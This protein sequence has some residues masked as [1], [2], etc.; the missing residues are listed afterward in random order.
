MSLTLITP[1]AA[2]PVTLAEAKAHLNVT[3]DADD[4][5]ITRLI[6][7][8]T[9]RFDGRDGLCGPLIE[10][11]WQA[12]FDGFPRGRLELPLP[13]VSAVTAVTYRDAA[14]ATQTLAADQYDVYGLDVLDGAYVLPATAW[15]A[16]DLRPEAVAVTFTA[17][18]GA[19]ADTVPEPIRQAILATVATLYGQREDAYLGQAQLITVP[20]VALDLIAS[21]RPW[22][23]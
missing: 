10:Q 21:H 23:F 13:P 5:L 15:P 17:G 6:A 19:A 8:A 1:P 7:A 18:Y 3:G 12:Q 9:A 11:T 16:T 22:S 2:A 14:G 20:A 4:A